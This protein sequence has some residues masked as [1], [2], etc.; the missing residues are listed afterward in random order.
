M[1]SRGNQ[2]SQRS[3]RPSLSASGGKPEAPARLRGLLVSNLCNVKCTSA[4]IFLTI[5]R[6]RKS[7]C[8][9]HRQAAAEFLLSKP[10]HVGTPLHTHHGSKATSAVNPVTKRHCEC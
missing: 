9:C 1:Q 4:E 3:E 6:R 2:L 10:K 7:K 5:P 8:S